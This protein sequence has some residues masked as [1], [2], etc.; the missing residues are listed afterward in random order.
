MQQG[1]ARVLG[2][3]QTV[4]MLFM[5]MQLAIIPNAAADKGKGCK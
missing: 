3:R 4:D 2:E 5:L 1:K